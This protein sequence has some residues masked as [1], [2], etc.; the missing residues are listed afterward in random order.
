MRTAGGIAAGGGGI[1]LVILGLVFGVDTEQ[2][3]ARQPAAR[4]PADPN[5]K[6]ERVRGQGRRHAGRRC[7]RTSSPSLERLPPASYEKPKLVLFSDGVQDRRVRHRPGRG[8]PV[9]LPGATRRCTSTRRSSTSSS[10]SSAGRRP[11]SRRPTSSPTRSGTTSRTCSATRRGGRQAAAR[12]RRTSTRSGWNSR[13]TTSPACGRTTRRRSSTS[14]SRGDVEAA[15]KTAQAI[16]DDRMQK[17]IGRVRPPGEVQPRHVAGSG[18]RRSTAGFKHRRR[19]HGQARPV[20]HRAVRPADE[21]N[22]TIA[23]FR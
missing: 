4:R 2:A 22:W 5:D 13:P 19:Q 23:L 3:R 8:R 15:L 12:G 11:S 6:Y 7:G 10:R 18:S 1:L 9:L 21:A 20:L 16:G 17:T 14:S